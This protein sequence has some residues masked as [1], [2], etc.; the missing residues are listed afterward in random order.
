M[1]SQLCDGIEQRIALASFDYFTSG[2]TGNGSGIKLDTTLFEAPAQLETTK[3]PLEQLAPVSLIHTSGDGVLPPLE[4]PVVVLADTSNLSTLGSN[5]TLP[6]SHSSLAE[7][8]AQARR[9]SSVS[10]TSLENSNNHN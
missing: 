7:V 8:V 3:A 6:S 5:Q 2:R 10:F 9:S 4:L 1:R